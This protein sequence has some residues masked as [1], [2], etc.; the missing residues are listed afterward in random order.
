VNAATRNSPMSGQIAL[1]TSPVVVFTESRITAL[2]SLTA[3]N[4]TVL[5]A[6]T[7]D[8]RIVKVR[9]LL[10]FIHPQG[11]STS[12]QSNLPKAASNLWGNRKYDVSW[13]SESL[14]PEQDFDLFSRICTAKPPEATTS[15]CDRQTYNSPHLMH[16]MR[17]KG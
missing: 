2:A 11:E 14:H 10:S 6:G 7:D 15:V 5:L 9:H 12:G 17:P 8:G 16:S 1:S 13:V 3:D 4:H